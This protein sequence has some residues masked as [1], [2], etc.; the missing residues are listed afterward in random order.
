MKGLIDGIYLDQLVS[1]T[2]LGRGCCR[3]SHMIEDVLSTITLPMRL[4]FCKRRESNDIVTYTRSGELATTNRVLNAVHTMLK[5][6]RLCI[7]SE[8]LLQLYSGCN[9]AL[10]DNVDEDGIAEY[11]YQTIVENGMTLEMVSII[12]YYMLT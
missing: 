2:I 8:T 7:E 9:V 3:I 11:L 10:G 12:L 1:N 6:D 4:M 5:S